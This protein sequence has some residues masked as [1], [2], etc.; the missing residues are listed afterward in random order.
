MDGTST[1]GSPAVATGLATPPSTA[2]TARMLDAGDDAPAGELA[3]R[4]LGGLALSSAYGAAMGMR[5]GG[6]SIAEHAIGTP[7]A[8]AAIT[9]LALPALY[10]VLALFDA[11]IDLRRLVAAAARGWATAGIALAGLA[12]AVALFSMTTVAPWAAAAI[13]GVGLLVGG[14]LGLRVLLAGVRDAM[15]EAD[16]ATRV[17]SHLVLGGFAIF[18]VVLAARI[19]GAVLPMFGGGAS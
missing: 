19:W 16:S 3:I 4:M 2:W 13:A 1:L 8:L 17:L 18:A 5:E 14:G 10:I 11:P 12:P 15:R 9:V 6:L 7:A